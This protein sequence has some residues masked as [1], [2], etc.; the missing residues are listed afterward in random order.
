MIKLIN[1]IYWHL[2]AI[3]LA[4]RW[5]TRFNLGSKV[6]YQGQIYTLVQGVRAPLWELQGFDYGPRISV[7]EEDMRLA[8]TPTNYWRSFA[9]GYRF[10]RHNWIDIWRSK[11]VEDWQRACNIWAGKPL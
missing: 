9:N 4:L 3:R 2:V 11:G 5:V 1:L 6:V 8:R 10:Y 7:R